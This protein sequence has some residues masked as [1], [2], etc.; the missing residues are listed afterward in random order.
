MLLIKYN[1]FRVL[2]D[3]TLFKIENL[4][5]IS[6]K[7]HICNDKHITLKT[8]AIEHRKT[9]NNGISIYLKNFYRKVPEQGLEYSFS[10]SLLCLRHLLIE[11]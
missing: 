8:K 2:D 11:E 7:L 4:V 1:L 3:P 6:I 9:Q 5:I 10:L